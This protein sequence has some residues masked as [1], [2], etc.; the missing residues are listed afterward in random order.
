MAPDPLSCPTYALRVDFGN[1]FQGIFCPCRRIQTGA[2]NSRKCLTSGFLSCHAWYGVL[3]CNEV[4]NDWF[5]MY[6]VC[7]T[8][9]SHRNSGS[10]V[11]VNIALASS[12]RV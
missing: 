11:A 9:D 6:A 2:P 12:T 4:V 3:P 5:W 1:I 7:S 10:S 8:A